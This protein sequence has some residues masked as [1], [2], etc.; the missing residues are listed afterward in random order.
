MTRTAVANGTARYTV[1]RPAWRRFGQAV[2]DRAALAVV[3]AIAGTCYFDP[4]EVR[5]YLD[6]LVYG[7]THLW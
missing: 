5:L 7:V 6:S 2:V 1:R 3:G 4:L